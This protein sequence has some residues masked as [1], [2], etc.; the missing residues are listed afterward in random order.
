MSESSQGGAPWQGERKG[1]GWNRSAPILFHQ[2][3]LGLL[4]TSCAAGHSQQ[5][6]PRSEPARRDGP[7]TSAVED[8]AD[9]DNDYILDRCD[10]CPDEPEMYNTYQ[11]GDGCPETI[12]ITNSGDGHPAFNELVF[13]DRDS[14]TINPLS[15][16]II[17]AAVEVMQTNPRVQLLGCVGQTAP[18]EANADQLAQA[19]AEAVCTAIAERGVARSRLE[20][21]GI[22]ARPDPPGAQPRPDEAIQLVRVVVMRQRAA[23]WYQGT[24]ELLRWNGHDMDYGN[25]D[26]PDEPSGQPQ[27]P[28]RD[29]DGLVREHEPRTP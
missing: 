11:D 27:C 18:T 7:I 29:R 15:Q 10:L 8:L 26:L 9:R 12:V 14:A 16:V 13:F 1:N 25:Q 20:A 4:I 28:G 5:S 17:D 22:G 19:R 2:L 6:T 23:E 24:I 3:L 21:H